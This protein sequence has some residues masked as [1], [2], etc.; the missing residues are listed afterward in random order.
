[1]VKNV[2]LAVWLFHLAV[3]IMLI[4]SCFGSKAKRRECDM[5]LSLLGLIELVGAIFV[6]GEGGCDLRV[7]LLPATMLVVSGI[8]LLCL[9]D[10]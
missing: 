4:L 1:M 3:L 9:E 2:A 6:N 5:G 7:L 10:S 8:V